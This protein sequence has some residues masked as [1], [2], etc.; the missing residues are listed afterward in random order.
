MKKKLLIGAFMFTSVFVL[1]SGT[2]DSSSTER[3]PMFGSQVTAW[4]ECKPTGEIQADGSPVLMQ[5]VEVTTYVFWIG[6]SHT[7][8]RVCN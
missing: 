3:R 5:E 2:E 8:T 4:T 6:F 7:E 1:N